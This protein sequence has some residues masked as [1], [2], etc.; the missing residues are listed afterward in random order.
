[1]LDLGLATVF[2][3]NQIVSRLATGLDEFIDLGLKRGSI[4]ILCCLEYGKQQQRY[5]A[6]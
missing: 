3:A 1:M 6:D 4:A 5:D 2:E